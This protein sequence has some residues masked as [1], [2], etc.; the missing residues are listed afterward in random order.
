EVWLCRKG[1]RLVPR[2]GRG[3]ARARFEGRLGE[4][5]AHT[6]LDPREGRGV[7]CQCRRGAAPRGVAVGGGAPAAPAGARGRASKFVADSTNRIKREIMA[8]E[9]KAA[10][11]RLL[12]ML[13][14][15]EKVRG[16]AAS[17][18]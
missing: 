8:F 17:A 14:A 18:V 16:N 5:A 4:G 1:G 13:A 3:A 6:R 9:A 11:A 15:V 2:A 10:V 12:A 7:A